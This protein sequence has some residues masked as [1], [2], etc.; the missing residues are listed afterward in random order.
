VFTVLITINQ[1]LMAGVAITGFSLLLYSLTFNLK[2]RVAR[3]FAIILVCLV[4][5]YT[6]ESLAS[7]A[8]TAS[9]G[10]FWLRFQWVG[11]VYLPAAY[12][13]FSDA[14]LATTGKPSRGKR[15]LVSRISYLIST[16]FLISL[17]LG[18]LVGPLSSINQPAAHLQPTWLTDVFMLYYTVNMLMSW[19]NFIRAFQRTATS[20][21]RRRMGYLLAGS[22]APTLGSFPFL[23]FTSGLAARH[24]LTFWSLS[25]MANLLVGGLVVVMAYSV[26]FFG[27]P[28]T[29][30]AVKSRLL[31]WILRG[32]VTASLVLAITTITR[33]IGE[34]Y[35]QSY[36]AF[37]PIVMAASIVLLEYLISLTFPTIERWLLYGNDKEEIDLLRSL[38]DRLITRND[39]HQFLEMILSALC[40]NLQVPGVYLASLNPEGLELVV[41]VGKTFFDRNE[42]SAELSRVLAEN[43]QRVE[44]FDW[45]DDTLVPLIDQDEEGRLIIVGLLGITDGAHQEWE[46]DQLQRLNAIT[47]RAMLALNDRRLQENVFKTI[48]ALSS[49]VEYIQNMR[50]AWRYDQSSVLKSE[51]PLDAADYSQW[52]KDALTHYWGGPK[53]TENPLLKLQVVQSMSGQY[54]GSAP[55]ALRALLKEAIERTRP[56]GER[57]FTAEWVLY[58]ILEMKFLEGKKVREI[59]LRLAMSEADLYRKQRVAIEAIARTILE[60]ESQN[61]H[62][63]ELHKAP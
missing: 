45:G 40:D 14:L 2:V 36:T 50:A 47:Q 7:V 60:M 4:T 22:L 21:S 10:E 53:L 56:D 13:H 3:S 11:I 37:V 31:K 63:S 57:R 58:N 15:I 28:Q 25:V 33:R 61:G 17:P 5:I 26:A 9:M 59:A 30:R 34:L 12:L 43:D 32:P 54:D 16:L 51:I 52:V 42:V 1:I 44:M 38:E 23:L 24:T 46:G 6:A 20:S 39:L 41:K 62:S 19:Y 8:G 29:D 18:L 27:A 49:K 35:G 48:E 55:N